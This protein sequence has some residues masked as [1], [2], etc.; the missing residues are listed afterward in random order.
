MRSSLLHY[1]TSQGNWSEQRG[2]LGHPLTAFLIVATPVAFS[3]VLAIFGP[4][5]RDASRRVV[6]GPRS[7]GISWPVTGFYVVVVAW[8]RLLYLR[9]VAEHREREEHRKYLREATHHGASNDVFHIYPEQFSAAESV[10]K[11]VLR[12]DYSDADEEAKAIA[13]TLRKVLKLCARITSKFADANDSVRYSANIMLVA[14]PAPLGTGNVY[15]QPLLDALRFHDPDDV[16]DLGGLL[17]LPAELAWN[18]GEDHP[19]SKK[20]L[21]SIP[22]PE[23]PNTPSGKKRALPGAPSALFGAG[24][25]VLA[26]TRDVDHTRYAIDDQYVQEFDEYFEPDGLGASVRSFVSMRIGVE[27]EN[28]IGVLNID[29]DEPEVLGRTQYPQTYFAIMFPFLQ[30]MARPVLRYSRLRE[31]MFEVGEP[32]IEAYESPEAP[33]VGEGATGEIVF[34]RLP[35]AEE[36]ENGGDQ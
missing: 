29:C 32:N 3:A 25:D 24:R 26:D 31:D 4:E 30:A 6:F 13:T 15:P 23:W 11:T 5:I 36:D 7:G 27:S 2:W 9:H 14:T 22:F 20:Q 19:T 17:Y 16:I 8:A 34:P 18:A 28:P 21:I 33:D 10:L 1:F 35:E 12:E